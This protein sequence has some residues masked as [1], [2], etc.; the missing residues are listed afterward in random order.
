MQHHQSKLSEQSTVDGTGP[1]STRLKCSVQSF[2]EKCSVYRCHMNCMAL[3]N[4]NEK[5]KS[6]AF[7]SSIS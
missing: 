2:L 6:K 7:E 1:E 3:L 4:D 5:G